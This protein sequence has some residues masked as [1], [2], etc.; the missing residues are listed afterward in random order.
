MMDSRDLAE[1]AKRRDSIKR[2]DRMAEPVADG[3]DVGILGEAIFSEATGLPLDA[4]E[5][6]G[7]DNGVDFTFEANGREWTVDVKTA[8]KPYYLL[9]EEG[10]AH[11]DLY[12]LCGFE[13]GL[14]GWAWRDEVCRAPTRDFGGGFMSHYIAAGELHPV[15]PM[16]SRIA[17]YAP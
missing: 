2:R 4:T 1:I 14:R 15:E 10:N 16:L 7:G 11:A 5:R 8:R 13:G 17:A 3:D 6:P 9:V 12:F